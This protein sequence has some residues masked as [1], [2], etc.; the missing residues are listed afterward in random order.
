MITLEKLPGDKVVDERHLVKSR[1]IPKMLLLGIYLLDAPFRRPYFWKVLQRAV[2]VYKGRGEGL[3]SDSSLTFLNVCMGFHSVGT[4]NLQCLVAYKNTRSTQ[5]NSNSRQINI[6]RVSEHTITILV[7]TWEST[8]AS[9][10][11]EKYTEYQHDASQGRGVQ[12]AC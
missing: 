9:I 12:L 6:L 7:F 10:L 8:E 3:F 2:C 11:I 4:L 1:G 5:N